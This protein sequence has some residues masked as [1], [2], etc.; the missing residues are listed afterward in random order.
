MIIKRRF[1]SFQTLVSTDEYSKQIFKEMFNK[2]N[3]PKEEIKRI[4]DCWCRYDLSLAKSGMGSGIP[5]VKFLIKEFNKLDK[6]FPYE[7]GLCLEDVN[8]IDILE[9]SHDEITLLL[10]NSSSDYDSVIQVVTLKQNELGDKLIGSIN[11]KLKF[12]GWQ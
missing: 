11:K 4:W 7:N 12:Y 8:N 9:K 6:N 3:L 10:L 2:S 5:D 1:V